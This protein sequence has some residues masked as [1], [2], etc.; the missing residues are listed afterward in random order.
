MKAALRVVNVLAGVVLLAAC[1]A[2]P[3]EHASTGLALE[4]TRW[5]FASA[6]SGPLATLAGAHQVTMEFAD[7]RVY[8]NAGCNR[9]FATY[10]L[11]GQR[12]TPEHPGSSMMYCEGEAMQ[13]E[14]AFLA[15]LEKPLQV[16]Q[17][18]RS[19]SLQAE[20]GTLLHFAPAPEQV[21]R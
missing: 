19:L 6:E 14:A 15:L 1:A 12:L 9:Y 10:V 11:D 7:G 13:V 2:S 4:G 3:G 16:E 5:Q 20:D 21:S 17:S 8:G 18:R